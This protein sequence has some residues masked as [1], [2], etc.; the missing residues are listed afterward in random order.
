[1]IQRLKRKAA[2][3]KPHR[4]KYCSL[5]ASRLRSKHNREYLEKLRR[6]EEQIERGEVIRFTN[7]EF[8]LF[9]EVLEGLSRRVAS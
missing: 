9:C 2:D 8:N 1:M 4:A 3:R 7:E 5:T 6:S